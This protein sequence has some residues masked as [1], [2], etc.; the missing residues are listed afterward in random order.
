MRMHFKQIKGFVFQPSQNVHMDICTMCST[1]GIFKNCS[2]Y[3]CSNAF[4]SIYGTFTYMLIS[5]RSGQRKTFPKMLGLSKSHAIFGIAIVLFIVLFGLVT[6]FHEGLPGYDK[7]S[8][9]VYHH[10]MGLQYIYIYLFRF[11]YVPRTA[12]PSL[13]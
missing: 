10:P 7:K 1:H 13:Q 12:L 4:Y 5:K 3:F 6:S 2:T 8:W 11:T 9:G